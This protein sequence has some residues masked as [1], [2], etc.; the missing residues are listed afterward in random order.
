M[1]YRNELLAKAAKL[2]LCCSAQSAQEINAQSPAYLKATPSV[3]PADMTE[4]RWDV[5]YDEDCLHNSLYA[6]DLERI[7]VPNDHSELRLRNFDPEKEPSGARELAALPENQGY[8]LHL[9]WISMELF[10]RDFTPGEEGWEQA[11]EFILDYQHEDGSFPV[12]ISRYMEHDCYLD[13]V[14]GSSYACCQVLIKSLLYLDFVNPEGDFGGLR[15]GIMD[16]LKIG[17]QFACSEGLCGQGY[18]GHRDMV[19][20]LCHFVDAGLI[21][22]LKRYGKA[23]PEFR[24]LIHRIKIGLKRAASEMNVCGPW[25]ESRLFG[26]LE[27]CAALGGAPQVPVF[28]YGTLMEGMCNHDLLD[29]AEYAGGAE[30]FGYDLYDLGPYPAIKPAEE[31]DASGH[32]VKGEVYLVDADTLRCLHQLEGEGELY[33]FHSVKSTFGNRT[34][35]VGIYEYLGEVDAD[36]E[37]PYDQQ[38]YSAYMQ[39]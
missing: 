37:I 28:V 26:M 34:N 10:A 9:H 16:A 13:Y 33:A 5:R 19:R 36:S 25:G 31:D 27:V 22:F 21:P 18:E 29:G 14:M 15:T 2:S 39:G 3:W 30:I 35:T 17:L 7:L 8:G 12:A 1:N 38:P 6:R 4:L 20:N 23:F 11:V 24:K 32:M